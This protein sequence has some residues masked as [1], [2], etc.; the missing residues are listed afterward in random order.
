MM[1][2]NIMK[3]RKT[4]TTYNAN[5]E[6]DD[7]DVDDDNRHMEEDVWSK[8][9]CIIIYFTFFFKKLLVFRGFHFESKVNIEFLISLLL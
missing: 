4:K 9:N 8:I 7:D 6:D 2:N 3:T 5:N 1:L